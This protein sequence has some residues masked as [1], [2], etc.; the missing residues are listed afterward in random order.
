MGIDLIPPKT[1]TYDCL[2]CQMGRT[3]HKTLETKSYSPVHEVLLEL[4]RRLQHRVHG[5]LH[6][7]REVAD[8]LTRRP[9]GGPELAGSKRSRYSGVTVFVMVG[10]ALTIIF[11]EP[12]FQ[13]IFPGS[14]VYSHQGKKIF[15]SPF[16]HRRMIPAGS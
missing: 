4:N 7:P 6:D 10:I 13:T 2:Y 14:S 1:C 11:T 9:T 3:T 16:P 12:T 8:G 15:G 5:A